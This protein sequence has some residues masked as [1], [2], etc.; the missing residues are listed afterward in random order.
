MQGQLQSSKR[1]WFLPDP[2]TGMKQ[3]AYQQPRQIQERCTRPLVDLPF[4]RRKSR[5]EVGGFGFQPPFEL[6][7]FSCQGVYLFPLF[8]RA[9]I[10]FDGALFQRLRRY[11]QDP[12]QIPGVDG[13][14]RP[15]G[16]D[17]IVPEGGKEILGHRAIMA[18]LSGVMAD[19]VPAGES[20]P[21]YL[22]E[23]LF[24][25]PRFEVFLSRFV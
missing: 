10:L 15:D 14:W 8:D 5:L 19:V 11:H 2:E 20:K 23:R 3:L 9:L 13:G 18:K 17:A 4:Q 7:V 1:S 16:P 12:G 24:S 6:S 25:I 21:S 22:S